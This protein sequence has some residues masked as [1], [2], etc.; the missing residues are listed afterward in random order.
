M[1]KGIRELE[2]KI[3]KREIVGKRTAI[4]KDKENVTVYLTK[5]NDGFPLNIN[6][7]TIDFGDSVKKISIPVELKIGEEVEIID[8]K[9][10][11]FDAVDIIYS[12][13]VKDGKLYHLNFNFKFSQ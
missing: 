5:M 12:K 6:I 11:V 7:Y 9:I 4:V 10:R 13:L 1:E 3:L 8:K 2:K